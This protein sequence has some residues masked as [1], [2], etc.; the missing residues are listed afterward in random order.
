MYLTVYCVIPGVK[1]KS[2]VASVL[3]VSMVISRS[4]HLRGVRPGRAAHTRPM[5][6][7]LDRAAPQRH[8]MKTQTYRLRSR[9]LSHCRRPL[10]VSDLEL[11]Y[12]RQHDWWL[13]DPHGLRHVITQLITI[14]HLA[15]C[16][17]YSALQCV[18]HLLVCVTHLIVIECQW[19][20]KQGF[21]KFSL[22]LNSIQTAT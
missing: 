4:H 12:T 1:L 13:A 20:S 10:N 11:A 14:K 16:L 7:C 5:A 18:N 9:R 6:W 17:V 21:Q 19:F 22:V 2:I 15:S 3:N 8:S